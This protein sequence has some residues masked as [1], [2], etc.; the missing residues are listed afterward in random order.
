MSCF[1]AT[2]LS[3]ENGHHGLRTEG[4]LSDYCSQ[5]MVLAISLLPAHGFPFPSLHR[6]SVLAAS[7]SGLMHDGWSL[8]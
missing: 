8:K 1:P 6:K 2:V 5:E 4:P 3:L 7:G